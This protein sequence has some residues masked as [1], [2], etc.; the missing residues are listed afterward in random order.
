MAVGGQPGG[1]CE[2]GNISQRGFQPIERAVLDQTAQT[3]W[4]T[5]VPEFSVCTC[6]GV[7]SVYMCESLQVCQHVCVPVCVCRCEG[8]IVCVRVHTC[9]SV[10]TH[11]C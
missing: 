2:D 7:M 5:K 3:H 10:C 9:V 4:R 6:Q 8:G 1:S 11:V